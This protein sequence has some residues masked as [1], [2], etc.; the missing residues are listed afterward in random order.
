MNEIET[1]T[2]AIAAPANR[3]KKPVQGATIWREMTV[4]RAELAEFLKQT[5]EDG[6]P[7]PRTIPLS[8]SSEN[9]VD[10]WFGT[11]IL[12]HN[13]K[14]VRMNR[15][16]SG[17]A[18]LLLEHDRT[19]QIGVVRSATIDQ[20]A[21]KGRCVVQMSRS[22]LGEEVYQ[23]ILDGIRSSVSVGYK[24]HGT[25]TTSNNDTGEETV[26]CTDWEPCEVS[27]ASIPADETVGVGR[28]E[29]DIPSTTTNP[30]SESTPM[31][32]KLP[33][34]R[35]L[36]PDPENGGGGAATVT[37]PATPAVA[38]RTAEI[39]V[40]NSKDT[41]RA[42][43][44]E[45]KRCNEIRATVDAFSTFPCA[46]QVQAEATKAI[47]DGRSAPDFKDFV[48]REIAKAKPATISSEPEDIG[49][50]EREVADYSLITYFRSMIPDMA[51]GMSKADRMK[52]DLVIRAS[53]AMA[54]TCKRTP[55]GVLLPGEILK[56][57]GGRSSLFRNK[58]PVT[59]ERALN[60]TNFA[61]GGAFVQT[62]I[63][64]GML[65]E[66]LR[67]A[68]KVVKMG[69]TT[70]SGLQ[71]NVAIPR[72]TGAA[73]AYWLDELSNVTPTQQT[74]GQVG[75]TPRRL[76]AATAFTKQF[77]AQSSV[78]VENFA[79]EDI[80]MI[81]AI[82]KDLAALFGTGDNQPLGIYNTS[83]IGAV[84]FGASATWA[85][86]IAFETVIAQ[87]N[88]LMGPLGYLTSPG[89][90][91]VWKAAP[92]TASTNANFLWG[93]MVGDDQVN[94][95]DADATNQIPNTGTGANA[96]F[97]G[98]WRELI[99]GEWEGID[100][101]VD[102]YTLSLAGQIRIVTNVLTDVCVRHPQSFC[103]STD[104]GNQ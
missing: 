30:P 42:T 57:R 101:V 8:F 88:A 60:A 14:A 45:R 15:M 35:L 22:P 102:P 5:R 4:D 91:G 72:Q 97:C 79:R 49:M 75:L 20:A 21:K 76:T 41:Q 39:V 65:I 59:A 95:Y 26:R 68:P 98:L 56:V 58:Y 77:L 90:K 36:P 78:D 25:Q 74:V 34:T 64:G 23:D 43:M 6:K 12:D 53:E 73:T 3:V 24:V 69:A 70:L 92:K 18:P 37:A 86:V 84:T 82:A 27:M 40:D 2:A 1:R 63:L 66:L 13:P 44:E 19:K 7:D 104:A 52:A 62:D 17:N 83:G 32:Q 103:V 28:T 46:G 31:K 93:N 50:N 16:N 11:E 80:M 85:K 87:A 9:P 96:V 51:Q 99:F 61:A 67:N 47:E 94:G 33:I 71:G 89:T 48:L 81:L 100:V 54:K 10:R 55:E 29:N 38:T